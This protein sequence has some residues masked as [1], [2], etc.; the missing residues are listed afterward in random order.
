MDKSV[1]TIEFFLLL[2]IDP[3]MEPQQFRMNSISDSLVDISENTTADQKKMIWPKPTIPPP[4]PADKTLTDY[5]PLILNA[6]VYDVSIE[7]PLQ[8]ARKLSV[9]FGIRY[10]TDFKTNFFAQ[11]QEK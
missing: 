9:S 2:K 10:Q 4:S 7:T 8:F 6:R 1:P 3:K 5:L 11:Q